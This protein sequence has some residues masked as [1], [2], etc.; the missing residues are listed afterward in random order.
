MWRDAQISTCNPWFG[1]GQ[2]RA[3][4]S[5]TP[6]WLEESTHLRFDPAYLLIRDLPDTTALFASQH[7]ERSGHVIRHLTTPADCSTWYQTLLTLRCHIRNFAICF[8]K[9]LTQP[10]ASFYK[11]DTAIC[12]DFQF[13]TLALVSSLPL[14]VIIVIDDRF[15]DT[16]CFLSVI[17]FIRCNRYL[18]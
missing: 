9:Y 3:S 17:C 10:W 8:V 14:I 12:D 18:I 15:R 6:Y 11:C 5:F 2:T 16:S 13:L 7:A 4:C 1:E